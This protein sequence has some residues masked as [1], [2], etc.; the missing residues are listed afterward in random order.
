MGQKPKSS[1][2]ANLVRFTFSGGHQHGHGGM[3]AKGQVGKSAGSSVAKDAPLNRGKQIE[4]AIA[5]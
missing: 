4:R 1:Q 2:R 5:A 3:S